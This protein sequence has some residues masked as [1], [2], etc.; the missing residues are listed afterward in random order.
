MVITS[1]LLLLSTCSSF[2]FAEEAGP[3]TDTHQWLEDIDT[4]DVMKWV[5]ERN[6][7][8][9]GILSQ[10]GNFEALQNK[11]LSTYNSKERIPY[12][13]KRGR[14]FYNFWKDADHPRGVWRRTTLENYMEKDGAWEE[15]LDL[16]ELSSKENENWVWHGSSCLRPKYTKCIVSLSRGGADADVKR[17]FDVQTKSFVADGFA[18]PEAKGRMSWIDKNTVLVST[19]FGEGSMTDS[20][21]P[22]IVKKWK[23]G[24]PLTEAETVLEGEKTDIS[25]GAYHSN[26]HGYK[27]TVV[28]RGITFYTN[29]TFLK[30]KKGL[31]KLEKQDS[32][33]ISLWKNHVLLELRKDWAVEGKTYKAGSFLT[34]PLKQWLR[35]EKNIQVLFEPTETSS[36]SRFSTTKDYLILS[37]LE[38]VKSKIWLLQPKKKNWEK[39]LFPGLPEFGTV[40]VSPMDSDKSNDYWLTVQDYI[41]PTTLSMGVVGKEGYQ[42]LKS[43]PSYFEA[44]GLQISQHF[45][46]SDDGTRIPYF[47]VSKKDLVKDGSNPTLLYGY[48]GFEISLIPY[49]SSSVGIG[50][51]EK[52]GVY[53]VANI[54]G[55]GEYGPR[56]HQAA[57]KEK[58]HKAYEDFSSVAKDLIK[59]GVTS[60]PKLGIKGGSN[61]GLLV[62]NMFTKYPEL[63]GAIVCQVPLLDMKRYTKLLAGASWM[64]EYGDPDKEDEWSYLQHN[65]PY[66]NVQKDTQYPPILI[67]TSTRDDRVHP[68]HARKM[69]AKIEEHEH[70]VLYYENIEGGHGGAANNEQA[71][72]MSSL[73][74]T[75]LWKSLMKPAPVVPKLEAK[76]TE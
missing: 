14:Y 49:Y 60:T 6:T 39:T 64:G 55:G 9:T 47:E 52:G 22:R 69:A 15:I 31:V 45:A 34:A 67:T 7:N 17:E 13:S 24:T 50:W 3:E 16:D 73:A 59:R 2:L 29:E 72:F 30:T 53:V 46:T 42:K 25:V 12:V 48:G 19:D 38:D 61:G 68:G 75:F 23:R 65:S 57:L 18:V 51:L 5:K 20:G 71:A 63:W 11:L 37:T 26:S 10:D 54:R 70:S 36:L 28:Y 76:E 35:G 4:D 33:N 58:R 40:I 66:H 41:T 56:W 43:L 44:S 1:L 8:T 21:Y 32:A 27:R 62:G 74:Y